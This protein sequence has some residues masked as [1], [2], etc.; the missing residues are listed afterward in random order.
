MKDEF[1]RLR[2]TQPSI[3]NALKEYFKKE[4]DSILLKML[5]CEDSNRVHFLRGMGTSY[6][7]ILNDMTERPETDT[8]MKGV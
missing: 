4:L 2:G 5:T 7:K 6:L 1:K 8:Q 3:F